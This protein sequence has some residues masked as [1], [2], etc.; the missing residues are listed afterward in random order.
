MTGNPPE[1]VAIEPSPY[2]PVSPA[3]LGAELAL[4]TNIGEDGFNLTLMHGGLT[5]FYLD[6]VIRQADG[7]I[8][9]KKTKKFSL[10]QLVIGMKDPQRS[11]G[12][13]LPGYRI[14]SH[15]CSTLQLSLNM[16]LKK[17]DFFGDAYKRAEEL[18]DYRSGEL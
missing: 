3:L 16:L 9:E 18:L 12:E 15:C 2:Q 10:R 1:V 11:L 13:L 7:T 6:L 4:G 5:T 17:Y 14:T 8:I